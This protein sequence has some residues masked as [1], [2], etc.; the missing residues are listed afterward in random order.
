M[1]PSEA[2]VYRPNVAA[3]LQREDGRIFVAERINIKGAWQFPQGGIDEGEDAETALFRELEEEIG[4]K[5]AQLDIVR[6][7]GG[8]RYAFPKG[9]LKYGIYGGQE[10]TYFLLCFRGRDEDFNLDSTHREFA[11]FQ[12]ILPQ[13]FQLN[14]APGFKRAV[15]SQVMRDFFAV[16]LA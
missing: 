14:W 5:R 10:Q 8:Y 4:V 11:R 13:E 15:Y 16:D 2:L 7:Q 1:F 6:S 9:R 12:W 3:I